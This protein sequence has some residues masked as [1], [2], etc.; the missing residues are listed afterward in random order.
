MTAALTRWLPGVTLAAWGAI[1]LHSY[2]AGRVLDLLHPMFR[3]GVL[4]AGL[5]M[6]IMA[7]ISLFAPMDA[8]CCAAGECGHPLS[9]TSSGKILTFLI[10][11]VPLYAAAFF[12][13]DE[14][15]KQAVLNRGIITDAAALLPPGQKAQKLAPPELPLP[16]KDPATAATAP[17]GTAQP[18]APA[19]AEESAP[20]DYLTR[21][22]EGFIVAE[23]LDLLYA[24]Q[25][26]A[27]RKDFEGKTVELTAQL[28]PDTTTNASGNRFKAVRMF[29]TCC[30]ADARP[31]ATIVEAPTAPNFPEMTWIKIIGTSTFP[32][33]N[34]KRQAVL[35]AD[36]IEKTSPPE[37]TMLY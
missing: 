26:N 16:T 35:K 4:V 14:F 29:M 18:A 27:L 5:L 36:R 31:V 17:A 8:E 9:R 34:G 21:T 3:P 12:S 10:L 2:F 7:I 23:V 6:S 25:D 15:S 20:N 24:A 13:K 32:V 30:A 28:M 22:P 33:E 37:E 11:I 19:A 1:L